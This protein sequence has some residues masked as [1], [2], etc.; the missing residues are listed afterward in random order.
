M[1]TDWHIQSRAPHCHATGRAFEEGEAVHSALFWRGGQ[2]QR[3]DYCAEAWAQRND[4]IQPLSHWQRKFKP[5]PPPP[6]EPLR[7]DDAES[8]LRCL[9]GE[10]DPTQRNARYILALM[11]E[12]KRLIRPVDV[13]QEPG[14]PRVL[15]YEH[16]ESGDMWLIEDPQLRLEELGPVQDEVAALLRPRQPAAEAAPESVDSLAAAKPDDA[17][18]TEA[19]PS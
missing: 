16:L 11:L 9:M 1:T 12:R 18:A 7:K 2:Y 5:L 6:A 17:V 4:N 3:E 15:V 8:L 13:R 10:N 14:G 19:F